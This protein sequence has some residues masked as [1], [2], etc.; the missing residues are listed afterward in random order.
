[1]RGALQSKE[2]YMPM[3]R[4]LPIRA[5]EDHISV[6]ELLVVCC[7]VAIGLAATVGLAVL[8]QPPPDLI[9]FLVQFG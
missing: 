6:R 1:M 4:T 8:L 9:T 3:R 5:T 2:D 7:L